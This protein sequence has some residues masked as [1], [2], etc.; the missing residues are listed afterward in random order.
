VR[1]VVKFH[2]GC[3]LVQCFKCCGYGHIA[4]NCRLSASCGHCAQI[5]ETQECQAK[6][7]S[8]CTNCTRGGKKDRAH[9][10]WFQSCFYRQQT[11]EELEHRLHS[12]SLTYAT[13][14]PGGRRKVAQFVEPQ[15]TRG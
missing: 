13:A 9:K 6:D 5:H 1:D 3:G 2:T 14:S 4:K 11:R 10:A 7:K 15:K 8:Q 12:A